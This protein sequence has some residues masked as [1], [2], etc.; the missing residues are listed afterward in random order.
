M[1][2]LGKKCL[3]IP[4]GV[5]VSVSNNTVLIEGPNG[6]ISCDIFE[7]LEIAVED[8]KVFVRNKVPDAR[9][10][11][12]LFKKID[13][14]QGLARTLIKNGIQGVTKGFEKVLEIHGTGF[15]AELKG[16]KLVLNL[17]FTHPVEVDI[18]EAIKVKIEKNT[19][20]KFSSHNKELLGDFV[21]KVR[22]IYPPEPYKGKG[23]RYAGEYVRHKVG[24]AA[25]GAQK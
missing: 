21:A 13:A 24:K 18:P 8:K 23:I 7:N 25:V 10:Y 19:V 22:D 2:R 3:E 14:L 15:K 9:R 5:R 17:G 16:N 20:M 1:S 6:K 4:D 12:R 11:R